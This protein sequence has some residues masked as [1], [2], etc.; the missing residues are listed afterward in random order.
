M[1]VGA[2]GN[3]YVYSLPYQLNGDIPIRKDLLAMR[4]AERYYEVEEEGRHLV[5]QLAC[6]CHAVYD[7][8]KTGGIVE[9]ADKSMEKGLIEG[10]TV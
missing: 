3:M 5:V 1:C 6:H 9:V 7:G 10:D 4:L 8:G 2:A